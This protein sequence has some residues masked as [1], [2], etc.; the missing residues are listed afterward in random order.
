MCKNKCAG[1]AW[2]NCFMKLSTCDAD[3]A[4]VCHITEKKHSKE[5]VNKIPHS[6]IKLR[7]SKALNRNY[8]QSWNLIWSQ[9]R[10][11]TEVFHIFREIMHNDKIVFSM[12]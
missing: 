7:Q 6:A 10:E 8:K 5:A 2:I 1:M 3:I 11:T 12:T 9:E 4:N